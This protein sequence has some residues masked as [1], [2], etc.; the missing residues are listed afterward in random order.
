MKYVPDVVWSGLLA[1]AVT[2]GGVFLSN[3]S[4][5]KRLKIQLK[6]D[7]QQKANERIS[8]LRRPVY[9]E[10]VGEL[11]KLMQRISSLPD[12]DGGKLANYI[13]DAKAYPSVSGASIRGDARH[14]F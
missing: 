8:T 6:H 3:A 10:C 11:V 14:V 4:N 7:E 1:S 13:N 5:N 12:I 2:L 9:I